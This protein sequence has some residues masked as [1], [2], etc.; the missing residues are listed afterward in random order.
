MGNSPIGA[1]SVSATWEAV[2]YE[3]LASR[4]DCAKGR[5]FVAA[6]LLIAG[7]SSGPPLRAQPSASCQFA[8][9]AYVATQVELESARKAQRRCRAEGLSACQVEFARMQDLRHRLKMAR[10][11]LDRYCTR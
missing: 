10:D 3:K 7:A 2:V 8:V 9:T 4:Q 11:Y 5:P 1:N 6:L